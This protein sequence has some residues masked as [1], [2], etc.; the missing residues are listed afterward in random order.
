M[1][2][3]YRTGLGASGRKHGVEPAL[4]VKRGSYHEIWSI[5]VVPPDFRSLLRGSEGRCFFVSIVIIDGIK[6]GRMDSLNYNET[7]KIKKRK[8]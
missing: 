2:E 1:R 4:T 6:T 3:I 5:R 7:V 8:D